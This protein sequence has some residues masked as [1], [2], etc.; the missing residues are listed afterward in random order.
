MIAEHPS[1]RAATED[2]DHLITVS[3]AQQQAEKNMQLWE[4]DG[5]SEEL[6]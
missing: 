1:Q 5:D 6:Q 4:S 3:I 2:L